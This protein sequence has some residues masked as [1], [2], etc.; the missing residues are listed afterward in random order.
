M[1]TIVA[2]SL[3]AETSK[4]SLAARGQQNIRVPSVA[5]LEQDDGAVWQGITFHA[6]VDEAMVS[7]LTVI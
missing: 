6:V 4:E 7:L 1:L 5:S 2:F 3:L